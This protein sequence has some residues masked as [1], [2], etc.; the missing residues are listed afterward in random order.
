M[1][2]FYVAIRKD[3][4]SLLGFPFRSHVHIFSW[5]IWPVF[6]LNVHIIFFFWFCFLVFIVILVLLFLLSFSSFEIFSLQR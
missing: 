5:V 4:V 3:L 2:L 1:V 6:A